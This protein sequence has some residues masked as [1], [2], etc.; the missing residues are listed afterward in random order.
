VNN[1][2]LKLTNLRSEFDENEKEIKLSNERLDKLKILTQNLTHLNDLN[3]QLECQYLRFTDDMQTNIHSQLLVSNLSARDGDIDDEQHQYHSTSSTAT[4]NGHEENSEF[5][6]VSFNED[7]R[8][9]F[10]D[11]Q[12]NTDGVLE[13]YDQLLTDIIEYLTNQSKITMIS[14]RLNSYSIIFLDLDDQSDIENRAYNILLEYMESKTNMQV[15]QTEK[16]VF[17]K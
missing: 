11:I 15:N 3:Q 8:E 17:K 1:E 9:E 14:I 12:Q 4:N 6:S 7:N 2:T 13:N 10:D 5:D 16:I